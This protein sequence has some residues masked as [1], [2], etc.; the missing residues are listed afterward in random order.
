[1]DMH[2]EWDFRLYGQYTRTTPPAACGTNQLSFHAFPRQGRAVLAHHMGR[3]T[4][5]TPD[6]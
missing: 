3:R 4:V 5:A 6:R 2:V 1:M